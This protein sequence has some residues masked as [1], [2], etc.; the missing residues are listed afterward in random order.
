MKTST[1]RRRLVVSLALGVGL[2]CG[3]I[4]ASNIRWS[5]LA[6]QPAKG[7]RAAGAQTVERALRAQ[8]R[9]PG[10]RAVSSR[11]GVS[12]SAFVDFPDAPARP[13]D[14]DAKSLAAANAELAPRV[15]RTG[16]TRR[17]QDEEKNLEHGPQRYDQPREAAEFFRLK[18]LPEGE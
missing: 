1:G 17:N 16:L 14:L 7:S 18:R 10:R 5:R 12:S 13:V 4:A 8:N 3:L 6:G 2:A 15:E 9:K 11:A